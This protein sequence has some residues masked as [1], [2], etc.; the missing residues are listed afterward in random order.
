MKKY[1]QL[2]QGSCRPY[3]HSDFKECFDVFFRFQEQAKLAI[4]ENITKNQSGRFQLLYFL[5]EFKKLTQKSEFSYVGIDEEN[6]KIF[7][8][9]IFTKGIYG[10]NSLDFQ[11]VAKDPDYIYNKIMKDLLISVF[12]KVKEGK[13]VYAVLGKRDKFSGYLTFLKRVFRVK[14]RKVDTLNRY[15]VEF[16]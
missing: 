13:Q 3:K 1:K 4:Y 15:H 5:E 7:A 10:E 6:G 16:P 8:I 14:V 12:S 2:K 9:A 11:F